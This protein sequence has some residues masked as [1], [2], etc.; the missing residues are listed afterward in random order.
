MAKNG[1][2]AILSADK[3]THT[4]DY[5][6]WGETSIRKSYTE[7]NNIQYEKSFIDVSTKK[8]GKKWKIPSATDYA[9]LIENCEYKLDANGAIFIGKNGHKLYFPLSGT[10]YG[11]TVDY[12]NG[13]SMSYSSYW[14][15]THEWI[16]D[17]DGAK[18]FDLWKD[19]A[20]INQLAAFH[21]L[22]VRAITK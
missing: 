16:D 2:F 14:T 9:E 10:K 5:Y 20:E 3:S 11:E 7:Q 8:M 15:S 13:V 19:R 4:G 18:N 17:Q 1:Q 6:A 21:G 12:G 22:N